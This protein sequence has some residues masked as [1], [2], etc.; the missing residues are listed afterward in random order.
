MEC[1]FYS[2]MKMFQEICESDFWKEIGKGIL[3]KQRHEMKRRIFE[4][5]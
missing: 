1:N 2:L 3:G 4:A 5:G